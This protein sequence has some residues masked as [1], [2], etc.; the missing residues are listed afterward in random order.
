M[1]VVK[2]L[3]HSELLSH[4]ASVKLENASSGFAGDIIS[5]HFKHMDRIPVGCHH[6]D[7]ENRFAIILHFYSS[8]VYDFVRSVFCMPH[9]SS[10]YN[11]SLSVDLEVPFF[12][13][14]LLEL[15][16]KAGKNN[17]NADC[18]LL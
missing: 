14:N 6:T 16:K 7:E 1:V 4:A 5:N 17:E 11:W 10:L 3:K 9:H 8:R 18:A 12:K 15:Q 2:E 13:D